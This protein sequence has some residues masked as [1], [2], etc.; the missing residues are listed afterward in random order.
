MSDLE[1]QELLKELVAYTRELE[2]KLQ[3]EYALHE[4]LL[5]RNYYLQGLIDNTLDITMVLQPDKS[6]YKLHGPVNEIIGVKAD[7]LLGTSIMDLVHPT[8]KKEFEKQLDELLK[9]KNKR[10]NSQL[11]C[12]RKDGGQIVLECVCR[13][14]QTPQGQT[15]ILINSRDITEWVAVQKILENS[16]N[17]LLLAQKIARIGS[18]EWDYEHDVLHWS[19]E[20][21]HIFGVSHLHNTTRFA[22]FEAFVDESDKAGLKASIEQAIENNAYFEAQFKITNGDGSPKIIHTK[23]EIVRDDGRAKIIAMAQDITGLKNAEEKLREYSRQLQHFSARQDRIIENERNQIARTIHDDIGQMLAVLKLD[24]FLL[25]ENVKNDLDEKSKSQ[26]RDDMQ[27]IFQRFDL[28]VKTVQN[29]TDNLRPEVIHDLGLAEAIKWLCKD[30]EK[31]SGISCTFIDKSDQL[32]DMLLEYKNTIFRIVQQGLANVQE[33]REA[34]EAR[35]CLEFTGQELNITI[36]DNG[37]G[38]IIDHTRHP[39]AM[40][41]LSMQER[42]HY[43]G[44]KFSISENDESLLS[45]QIPVNEILFKS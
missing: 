25:K 43:L 11:L 23:G 19:N 42:S 29:I 37:K 38:T 8:D 30:F 39:N 17:Q 7:A 33:H 15:Q 26:Y 34:T 12:L 9:N 13:I 27:N 41:M 36:S 5:S 28:L 2:N 24:M 21:Q 4:E 16:R 1:L 20:L 6:I 35:V 44:G 3:K 31:Q 10:S 22:E 40:G 45:L 18:W 14:L 32:N